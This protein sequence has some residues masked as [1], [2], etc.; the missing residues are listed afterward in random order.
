MTTR[1]RR[2]TP[3]PGALLWTTIAVGHEPAAVRA[4]DLTTGGLLTVHELSGVGQPVAVAADDQGIYFTDHGTGQ[5]LAVN[6]G[7]G[8]LHP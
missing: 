6:R 7:S 5:V 1:W 3:A 2:W 8:E 4:L